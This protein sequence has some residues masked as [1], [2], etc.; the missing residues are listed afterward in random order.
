MLAQ[1]ASGDIIV[2]TVAIDA[3]RA[4]YSV[5]RRVDWLTRG[6]FFRGLS[7]DPDLRTALIDALRASPYAAYRWE[8]PPFAAGTADL[9]AEFVLVD[10]GELAAVRAD[11]RPFQA[12]LANHLPPVATF[13]NLGGDAILVVPHA[14]ALASYP[15]LAA[16]VRTAPIDVAQALWT[17][18]GEAVADRS[19]A[20]PLWVST[21]GMGVSWL[22]V[23]LDASP[24]YYAH[25]PYCTI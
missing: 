21:A 4:T 14:T 20:A 19:P 17:A 13:A 12:Q 10:A 8:T 9:P 25:R 23:R 18:V 22:H 24:K 3:D 1:Y 5:Y 7:A 16:F 6:D 2:Q 15:H 11:P